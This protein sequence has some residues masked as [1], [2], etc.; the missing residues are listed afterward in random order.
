MKKVFILF[1][2]LLFVIGVSNSCAQSIPQDTALRIGRLS[3]GLTYYIRHNSIPAGRADFYLVQKVGSVLEEE[4]Q[5]GL[6]HFLEHM[7]FNGSKNFP[8]NAIITEMEKKGIRFGSNINAST[9]YDETIYKLVNIPLRAGI[10]DTA[11][12]ILHDWSGFLTLDEKEIDKERGVVREEWRI[13]SGGN[14]RV[15]QND[16]FP[17]VYAGTPYANRLPI[18]SIDVVNNFKYQELRDYYK[19]WY[20]PDLQGIIIVGD[21]NVTAIEAQIKRIFAD[22]P[23]PVNPAERVYVSIPGNDTPTIVYGTDKEITGTTITAFWKMDAFSSAQKSTLL[24]YKMNQI[25][26]VISALLTNRFLEIREKNNA[27]FSSAFAYSSSFVVSSLI[28]A[29]NLMLYPTDKD[30]ILKAFSSAFTEIERM[31]RYGFTEPELAEIKRGAISQ[32]E[33]LYKDR[34]NRTNFEFINDYIKLFL[35]NE[36]APGIEW[37]YETG[38]KIISD[39]SIDTVNYYAKRSMGDH[40]MVIYATAPEEDNRL[41]AKEDIV[42]A[43]EHAKT[44]ALTPYVYSR[45]K[46]SLLEKVPV[47][48]KIIHAD[49]KPHGFV[50][51]T[52]SNGAKVWFK[53][54]DYKEDKLI[55]TAFSPG[56]YSQVKDQDLP[57]GQLT[58][59]TYYG[60][61]GK[62]SMNELAKANIGKDVWLNT[63]VGEFSESLQGASSIKDRETLFQLM[64]LKMTDPRKDQQYF[65]SWKKSSKEAL[66]DYYADPGVVFKDTVYGIMTNHHPRAISVRRDS[67]LIDKVNYDRVIQIYKERFGNAADFTFFITGHISGDSIRPLVEQ[68]FGGLPSSHTTEVPKDYGIYPPAG[69][70]KKHFT[71]AMATPKSNVH[72][73]YTGDNIPY[74]LENETLFSYLGRILTITY[75]ETMRE[76]EGGV[77]YINAGGWIDTYPKNHFTF[78]ISFTTDPDSLKKTRLMEIMYGEIDKLMNEGPDPEKVGKARENILKSMKEWDSTPNANYWNYTGSQMAIHGIDRRSNYVNLVS[79]VTPEMVRDFAKKVFTQGNLIEIVMDPET[80]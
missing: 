35:S 54:T 19:K 70:V 65:D 12:L 79:S 22:I 29:W 39:L 25:N 27:P 4:N 10:I 7:A 24:W 46:S 32:M 47:P 1:Y 51:W 37:E 30:G 11:L 5:R 64:Y 17:V 3:N 42:K 59:I 34:A 66:K 75:N 20:R 41:P 28:P 78:N 18:G 55:L 9:S 45:I 67:S 33:K 71:H 73:A 40:N 63:E 80:R 15:L 21:I 58:G 61:F 48:G 14:L 6:A 36:P 60:K 13:S 44:A 56:G 72:V 68:Y 74:N 8:G 26:Q 2:Q 16:I 77:Y 23:A 50:Q 49:S 52:L 69:I 31:H 76:K 57:S 43:W 38:R 53:Q 62:F